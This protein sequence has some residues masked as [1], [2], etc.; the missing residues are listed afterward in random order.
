MHSL[1]I[2]GTDTDI[3]KTIVAAALAKAWRGSGLDVGVLKPF[4]CGSHFDA[5]L[6]M[7]ASQCGDPEDLVNPQYFDTPLASN[8]AA[9]LEQRE[10]DLDT[11]ANALET[12]KAKHEWLIVEGLGGALAPITDEVAIADWAAQH[13]LPAL[14]VSRTDLGMLNHTR[15]TIEALQSRGV[16][17][18][19][20]VLNRLHGGKM[21]I[22]EETNPDNLANLIDVPVWGPVDFVEGITD[23]IPAD[24]AAKRLP[25]I[26]FADEIRDRLTQRKFMSR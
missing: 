2:T 18:I 26:P 13:D 5:Q 17:V 3:G 9:K 23:Q 22:A 24:E 11:A 25:P 4:A 14:V 1:L 21:S 7:A 12:L 8:I 15:M 19:G 20:V 16:P 6:L 10:V